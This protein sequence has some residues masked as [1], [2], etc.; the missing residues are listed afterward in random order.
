VINEQR[1]S[2]GI[3]GNPGR[4]LFAWI[5]GERGAEGASHGSVVPHESAVDIVLDETPSPVAPHRQRTIPVPR[6]RNILLE[7]G[8]T[9][10]EKAT[11]ADHLTSAV[12]PSANDVQ[13]AGGRPLFPSR[14]P[15]GSVMSEPEPVH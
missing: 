7:T 15:I 14:E 5:L 12:H 8:P 4:S 2:F 13:I 6:E 3:D 11:R 9:R 1:L 10:N